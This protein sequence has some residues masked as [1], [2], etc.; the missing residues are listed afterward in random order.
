M[1][2]EQAKWDD[3]I[4]S[5]EFGD[6][7]WSMFIDG[8]FARDGAQ[9]FGPEFTRDIL[10]AWHELQHLSGPID[11]QN[12]REIH[13]VAC[14]QGDLRDPGQQVYPQLYECTNG[15]HLL[16]G[17]AAQLME[18]LPE[19]VVKVGRS[20]DGSI[21]QL[22][23]RQVLDSSEIM[24]LLDQIVQSYNENL[25][26]RGSLESLSV[27]LRSLA[28]LHPFADCNG[29]TRILLLQR[30]LRRLKLG[31]GA[32]MYNNNVN[33]YV[34][35]T[36]EFKQSILEGIDMAQRSLSLGANPWD[37]LAVE[38]HHLNFP[39]KVSESCEGQM[40]GWHKTYSLFKKQ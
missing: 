26:V 19:G 35:T 6:L 15:K 14:H 40:R 25:P 2:P 18:D 1:S 22:Q 24:T 5:C 23:P 28:W 9:A 36:E 12:L 39:L 38:K 21:E 7:D 11:A 37:N 33:I 8:E 17:S 34:S 10:K 32:F 4:S 30:E 31:C 27:F 13:R 16:N 29:R 3:E 20:S